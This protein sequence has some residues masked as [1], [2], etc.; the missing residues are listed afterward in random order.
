[1][2]SGIDLDHLAREH[3]DALKYHQARW[4]QVAVST[5][6]ADRAAAEEGVDRAYHAAGLAR[7]RKILWCASPVDIE[8]R[9]K[10]EWYNTDPGPLVRDIVISH[11][12]HR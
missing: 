10:A 2:S 12:T 6:P 4:A 8:R 9:R 3:E 7:P 5:A 11:H 1:M